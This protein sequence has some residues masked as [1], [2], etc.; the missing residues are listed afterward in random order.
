M[1]TTDYT[2]TVTIACPSDW[3]T[4]GNS[5]AC[6][7]GEQ[8]HADIGTFKTPGYTKD[9]VDYVGKHTVVRHT[10]LEPTQTG[11]L[12]PD[13]LDPMPEG[14]S[15]EAAQRAFDGLN[16]PG[17]ILM[18]VDVDP[19]AQFAEWGLVKKENEEEI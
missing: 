5:L 18:A 8:P 16:T 19:H 15:R 4:D 1:T 6:L 10:F 9:G 2:H 17:G 11:V 14:Y 3:V 7:L 12:P 13:P